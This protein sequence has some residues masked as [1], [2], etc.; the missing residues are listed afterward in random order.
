MLVDY[1]VELGEDDPVLELPWQSEDGALQFHNL[2][3]DPALVDRI[4]E[5]DGFPELRS[6]LLRINTDSFP[7]QTLKCDTWKTQDITSEEELF[8]ASWKACCYVDFVFVSEPEQQS[9]ANH[10]DFTKKVCALLNRA[11]EI[12]ASVELIIRR[13]VFHDGCEGS[14]LS[15][16]RNLRRL[17]IASQDRVGFGITAYVSGFGESTDSALRLR[18]IALNLFQNALIQAT[19]S[20]SFD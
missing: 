10:E 12:S 14:C 1:V 3:L 20:A 13:A 9:F 8:T 2:K 11:P 6:F 16:D 15:S 19:N 7:L 18:G 5:I 4:S 17:P